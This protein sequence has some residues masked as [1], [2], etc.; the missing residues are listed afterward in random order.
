MT[1]GPTYVWIAQS[2]TQ[3]GRLFIASDGYMFDTAGGTIA[4]SEIER[5]AWLM[6]ADTSNVDPG[7]LALIS[8]S[9]VS[10]PEERNPVC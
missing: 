10:D 5:N 7:E 2:M 4:E 3:D 1:H 9:Y 6:I 8:F